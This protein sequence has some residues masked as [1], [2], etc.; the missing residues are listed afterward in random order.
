MLHEVKEKN[1]FPRSVFLPPKSFQKINR[2]Y[3]CY[4]YMC[5]IHQYKKYGWSVKYQYPLVM[6]WKWVYSE[7]DA[8]IIILLT[9]LYAEVFQ[10]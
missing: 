9:I 8:Y 3:T 4:K 10:T 7:K 5:G 1:T 6:V 2:G